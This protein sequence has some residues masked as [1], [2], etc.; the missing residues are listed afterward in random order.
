M[1]DETRFWSKVDA[2]GDCWLWTGGKVRDGYGK[3]G[4]KGRTVQAHRFAYELVRGPIPDGLTIDHLC[5]R[6]LCV[7]PNHLEPVTLA[8]NVRRAHVRAGRGLG[9][10]CPSGHPRDALN[11]KWESKGRGKGPRRYCAACRRERTALRRVAA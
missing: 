5:A 1:S 2:S 3:F 9:D 10:R 11:L 8:E 4:H 7:N 6:P